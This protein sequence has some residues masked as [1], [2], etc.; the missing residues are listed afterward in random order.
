MKSRIAFASLSALLL[1]GC[2]GEPQVSFKKE[3][4]PM[5][6]ENCLE[7]HTSPEGKG[8][9]ASG[10]NMGSYDSLMKGT[11]LGPII[12]PNNSISST[13]VLLVS[14]KADP[15]IRM[16]HGSDKKELSAEQIDT[17]SRWIDQGAQNN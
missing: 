15:S 17:L 8:F 7:C 9:L 3:I 4:F 13:L 11:K 5:L 14:G 12:K 16:P 2:S 10:L 6:Q 1:A